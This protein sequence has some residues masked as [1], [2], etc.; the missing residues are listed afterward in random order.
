LAR[1]PV[2]VDEGCAFTAAVFVASNSRAF[3]IALSTGPLFSKPEARQALSAARSCLP[4]LVNSGSLASHAA[5]IDASLARACG[6]AISGSSAARTI[7][8]SFPLASIAAR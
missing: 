4:S 2:G 3:F 1:A 8:V 6:A 5:L 7:P